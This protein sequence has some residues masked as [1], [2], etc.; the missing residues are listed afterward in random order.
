MTAPALPYRL[1]DAVLVRRTV[2]SPHLSRLTFGSEDVKGMATHAADQRIKI[3]FPDA[4]GRA[5][6]LPRTP[7][8]L[9]AYKGQDAA[10]RSPMRTYTIRALRAEAGEVDVDFVLHGETGPASAWAL[11]ASLGDAVQ[12]VA[13]DRAFAGEGGGFE[14]KP[15]LDLG[16]LLLMADE[17]G[18]PAAAGI[19]EELAALAEPPRTQV[20]LE[21]PAAAD[22]I[23]LPTWPG[24]D[25]EWLPRD[26]AG[27]PAPGALLVQAA[28]RAV[29]TAGQGRGEA[30]EEVDIDH[31]ILWD[32]AA[33]GG[34]NDFYAWI[35]AE[36]GAVRSIRNLMI[37]ERGIDRASV[38]LMGYWRVGVALD[39]R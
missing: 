6:D 3:F 9:A 19:L 16:R 17:T 10:R 26:G 32:R 14:W 33:V 30:L 5:A 15:P 20:F 29:P 36:A 2:L 8:W 18:L 35:A 27:A 28:D 31:E 25:V 23:A 22:R 4:D 12:I 21:V 11:N 39:D 7:D 37:K 34:S 38:N 1:F 13:P 24:L